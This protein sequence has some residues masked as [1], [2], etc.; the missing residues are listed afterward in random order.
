MSLKP[1]AVVGQGLMVE[2]VSIVLPIIIMGHLKRPLLNLYQ[3]ARRPLMLLQTE[4][5]HS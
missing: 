5:W 4:G 3:L 2:A 1:A